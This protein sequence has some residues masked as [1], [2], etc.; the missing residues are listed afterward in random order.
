MAYAI[1][2]EDLESTAA[3]RITNYGQKLEFGTAVVAYDCVAQIL[4]REFFLVG[5]RLVVRKLD[6]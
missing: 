5:C 6:K 3:C 1:Y 2:R 4:R